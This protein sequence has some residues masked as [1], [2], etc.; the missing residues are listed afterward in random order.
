MK[1]ILSIG[2][3]VLLLLTPVMAVDEPQQDSMQ[4]SSDAAILMEQQTGTVL[5]EKNA[6]EHLSPASVTKVMTILLIAEQIDSGALQRSD[7]VTASATAAAMGGSQIYLEAGE[8]MTVDEMLKCIVVAS[9][10]DC[11]VAMAE[12]LSGTESAFVERM[13]ARA[14]ELGLQDT[15]F[16]N[17]TGLTDDDAH[18]TSAYDIAVMTR[19]VMRHEWLQDFT[20]IWTDTI[21]G[22]EFGL[23]NTNKLVRSF[24]G[25]IGLKTGFTQKDMYC[26]SAVAERG[27]DRFIAVVLHAPDSKQR[28]A[29]AQA[30]LS[31][32][33]AGY[34]VYDPAADT[35]L[36]PVRITLGTAQSIQPVTAEQTAR[37]TPK[38]RTLTSRCELPE[39][40]RAPI[41]AGQ[42][43]GTLELCSGD[44]VI[45]QIPIISPEDVPQITR[46]ALWKNLL[47]SL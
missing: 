23:T 17:C 28:F 1:Q 36:P 37:V 26:L 16:V 33:F 29:D 19:E 9:A 2:L 43:I 8:S 21:R 4:L 40:I 13:N 24:D 10:N 39:S 15:H 32:A 7:P 20:T 25:T 14:A 11:A 6:H 18:Y 5:Y 44:E 35:L 45:E 22:G 46:I 34:T 38:D 27:G 47:G 30:M 41:A 3:A 31:Y 42:Q 12:H